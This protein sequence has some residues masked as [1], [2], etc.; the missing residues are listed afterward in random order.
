[1]SAEPE[2]DT[3]VEDGSFPRAWPLTCDWRGGQCR[4]TMMIG[5]SVLFY[6]E[7]AIEGKPQAY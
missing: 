1:M 6:P 3:N 7:V 2:R 4:M 5:V